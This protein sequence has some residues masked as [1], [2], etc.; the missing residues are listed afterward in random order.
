MQTVPQL[1]T[2]MGGGG[3]LS[4]ESCLLLMPLYVTMEE[5]PV[6]HDW[7]GVDMHRNLYWVASKDPEV[8]KDAKLEQCSDVDCF[9]F[10]LCQ[11]PWRTVASQSRE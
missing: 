4:N 6:F 2:T 8:L 5:I 11:R 10:L 1:T 3:G 7:T 9:P